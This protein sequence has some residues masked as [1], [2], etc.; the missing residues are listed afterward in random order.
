[1]SHVTGGDAR[2]H[3]AVLRAAAEAARATP[4]VAFLRPGLGELLRGTVAWRPLRTGGAGESPGAAEAADETVRPEQ[5]RPG[6]RGAEPGGRQGRVAGVRA[7]RGP[8]PGA[9]CIRVHLAV[10]RGH[11]ALDVARAVRPRV[12]AA[13][14][15]ALGAAGEAAPAV[16]VTVTVTDIT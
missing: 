7:E 11:R 8:E 6:P 4:G 10:R 2:P 1:M 14:Q 3:A 5:G 16:A 12:A 15:E 13:V 9:W